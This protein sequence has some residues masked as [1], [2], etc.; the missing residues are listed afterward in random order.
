M[1]CVPIDNDGES[2]K[3]VWREMLTNYASFLNI[4]WKRFL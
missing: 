4:F 1:I 3:D 2:D